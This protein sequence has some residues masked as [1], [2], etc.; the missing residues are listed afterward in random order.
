[1][2]IDRDTLDQIRHLLRPLN[3]KLANIGAR[4]VV[5]LVEDGKKLQVLQ[6]GVL[7]GED[8]DDAEHHQ[9]YGFSSVPLGGAEAVLIFPNCDRSHPLV[10][11]VSDRRYR[12]TDGEP[13]EVTVYNHTG[14]TIKITEDG[15]IVVTPAAGR[16]VKIGSDAADDPPV[17]VSEIEAL[18]AAIVEWLPVANDGGSSLKAVF[19]DW[20]VNG[21]TKL[22]VE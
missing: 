9:P 3:A 15:D 13:G 19:A 17:L 21:A 12:P 18:K 2:G 22:D 6:L 10:V 8:I 4:G 11:A 1:M 16:K 20:D 5:Q 7:E 14:A